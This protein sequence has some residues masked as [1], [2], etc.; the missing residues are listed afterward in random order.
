MCFLF[1]FVWANSEM[2]LEVG[3]ICKV[4]VAW[5]AS[6]NLLFDMSEGSSHNSIIRSTY[7]RFLNQDVSHIVTDLAAMHIQIAFENE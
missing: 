6:N 5:I 2:H 3:P 7:S 4:D 1:V